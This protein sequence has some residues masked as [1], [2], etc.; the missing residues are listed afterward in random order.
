[1]LIQA[2]LGIGKGLFEQGDFLS[3]QGVYD[4]ILGLPE[5]EA[6]AEAQYYIAL[7]LRDGE[8]GSIEAAIP[9]FQKV[10]DLYP[11]S[12]F[13]GEALGELVEY[14]IKTGDFISAQ[15]RLEVIFE[16]HPDEAWL[17]VMLMRWTS[18]A[19]RMGNVE[20]ALSKAQQL[21][22]DYPNIATPRRRAKSSKL[23]KQNCRT[24]KNQE[25]KQLCQL[26]DQ[27]NSVPHY[28][29]VHCSVVSI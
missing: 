24:N 25:R 21:V 2:L 13:A 22:M 27:A 4:T 26:I 16:E 29:Y 8:K 9:A 6:K 10:A 14:L 20:L 3:A 23:S 17:D 1:M 12:P 19:Y 7:I 5:S 11:R 18:L 28:W 15:D